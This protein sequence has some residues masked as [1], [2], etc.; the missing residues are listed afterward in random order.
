MKQSHSH[1]D[2]SADVKY[3]RHVSAA[4]PDLPVMYSGGVLQVQS[5]SMST[6]TISDLGQSVDLLAGVSLQDRTNGSGTAAQTE[7][8]RL[9]WLPCMHDRRP[10]YFNSLLHLVSWGDGSF[11]PC[12]ALLAA[13]HR[14]AGSC[15][16][17][18]ERKGRGCQ[19]CLGE[20]SHISDQIISENMMAFQITERFFFQNVTVL[21]EMLC[22]DPQG[23]HRVWYSFVLRI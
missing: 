12:R 17:G 19:T 7:Q 23:H 4:V 9:L 15:T 16:T 5:H 13:S 11:S 6:K 8:K 21:R 2:H 3:S 22:F 14:T 10:H 18:V 20:F 1:K